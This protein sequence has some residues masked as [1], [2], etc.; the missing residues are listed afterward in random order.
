M[1]CNRLLPESE[2]HSATGIASLVWLEKASVAYI[3]FHTK[4]PDFEPHAAQNDL[5][6]LFDTLFNAFHSPFSSKATH[7]GQTLIWK[8]IG[9]HN[10]AH[11]F[12]LCRLLTH[13]LFENAGHINKARIGRKLMSIAIDERNVAGAREAF[14]QMSETARNDASTR[15]LA[16]K[17]ALLSKDDELAMESL[18]GIAKTASKDPT[19]LFACV[20]ESQQHGMDHFTLATLQAVLSQRPSGVQMP[21]LLRCTARLAVSRIND[22]NHSNDDTVQEVVKIFETASQHIDDLRQLAKAQWASEVQWWCKNSYNFALRHCKHITP[23]YTLRILDVCT[24][25]IDAC[26]TDVGQR[27]TKQRKLLC[28]FLSTTAL[29]VMGR[30][31]EVG[32]EHTTQCFAHAQEQIM[33]FKSLQPDIASHDLEQ[34]TA[35][36]TFVMLKFDLECILHLQQWDRLTGVLQECLEVRPVERWD[37]LAD[38]IIIMHEHLDASSEDPHYETMIQVLQRMINDTWKKQKEIAKVARWVRFTFMLCLTHMQGDFSLRLLQQAATMAENG[39]RGKQDIYPGSELQ[40]LTTTAFNRAVDFLVEG[41]NEEEARQ[42]MDGA[43]A[44]AKWSQD[45]G[46]LHAVLTS[47]KE[48]AQQHVRER[49]LQG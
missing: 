30:S 23:E 48:E 38:L 18:Q 14:F 15:F 21:A 7:A 25:F 35:A 17:L 49:T 31:G 44:L 27:E 36:R 8:A 5:Q 12:G 6:K 47:K 13:A 45:N 39:Y 43:L 46:S 34:E 42:W 20:L 40:W 37:A 4:A 29:I 41:K 1:I 11:V 9:Q 2:D 33:K 22:Q 16:F 3:L 26:P 28:A 24:T 10:G 32:S 19:Y